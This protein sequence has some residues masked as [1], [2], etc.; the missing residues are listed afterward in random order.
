MS[1]LTDRL[2]IIAGNA[3]PGPW[4]YDAAEVVADGAYDI[5]ERKSCYVVEVH[6]NGESGVQDDD[7]GRY[8]ETFDPVL[9][10]A[11]LDVIDAVE[12]VARHPNSPI[13][14]ALARFREVAG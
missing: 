12:K 2:R 6:D 3:S 1:D 13:A 7:D 9:V 11:M 10:V 14:L 4:V 8:I 5:A